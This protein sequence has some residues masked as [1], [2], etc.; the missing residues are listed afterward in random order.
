MGANSHGQG[1]GALRQAW[2]KVHTPFAS[3]TVLSLNI[4]FHGNWGIDLMAGKG[5]FRHLSTIGIK[6]CP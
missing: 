4:A 3:V 5:Q 6:T 1:L 2:D